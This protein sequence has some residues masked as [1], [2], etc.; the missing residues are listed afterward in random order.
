[1][2]KVVI[3]ILLSILIPSLFAQ[4]SVSGGSTSIS[5]KLNS[6]SP[7]ALIILKH[8]GLEDK[9]RNGVIDKGANEGYENF[10]AKYGDADKGFYAN[11]ITN[12]T[13]NGQLEEHEITNHYYTVIRFKQDFS[14]ETTA[15]ENEV[16]TYIYANNLPLVWLDD[17]QETVMKTVNRILGEGW[18]N[19]K[20]S[21]TEAEKIFIQVMDKLSIRQL[22]GNPLASRYSYKQLPDFINSREGCCFEVAQFGFWFFSQLKI[23]SINVETA[24]EPELVH[25]VIKL[26]DTNK[27]IDYND[28]SR[29]YNISVNQWAIRNP[30]QCISDYYFL[31]AKNAK[32]NIATNYEQASIYNK[33]DIST[34]GF[35]MELYSDSKNQSHAEITALGEFLL[36]NTDFRLIMNSKALNI[37]EIKNNLKVI[38]SMLIKSYNSMRNRQGYENAAYLLNRYFQNDPNVQ[39]FIDYYKF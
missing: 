1:M 32:I 7:L 24:L 19:K 23:K 6:F 35:L 9:N 33:Y 27:I 8:L 36:Q 10:T 16:K 38:L 4:T 39:Q 22:P 30:L 3:I 11:G 2:K 25:G 37:A 18:Q 20:P 12:G 28:T 5:Q 21:E 34:I 13:N 29:A 31:Q 14:R 26:P 17:K 15:I